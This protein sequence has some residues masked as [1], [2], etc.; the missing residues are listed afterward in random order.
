M[1]ETTCLDLNDGIEKPPLDREVES[2][3]GQELVS[4]YPW[5]SWLVECQGALGVV[6]VSCPEI[7]REGNA[8]YGVVL[9]ARKLPRH[10]DIKRAAVMAGG[11]LLERAHMSRTTGQ[12]TSEIV[13][14]D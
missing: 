3:I 8:D 14:R 5:V 4:R 7:H 10:L 1:T 9:M 2:A 6:K 13:Q 11:E 12:R